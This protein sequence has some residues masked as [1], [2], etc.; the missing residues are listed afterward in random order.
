[1]KVKICGITS[2]EDATAAVE[3][4]ADMLGFN[5]YPPSP[6]SL[7]ADKA[8]EIIASLRDRAAQT[9][10]VGVFV[11]QRP[12]TV[13]TLFV[14]CGLDLVQLSGD[15][16]PREVQA[17]A[18]A[19]FK[20]IRPADAAQAFEQAALYARRAA[21][22]ALLLDARVPGQYGGTGQTVDWELA[23]SL[24]RRVP[25]LLAGGLTPENLPQAL[26]QVRPWGV[27]VAS[28]VESQPGVKDL[29][30]MA[31]FIR[32]ARDYTGAVV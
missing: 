21:A 14:Q 23:S 18:P 15:E 1:V 12:E 9:E 7:T 19:A 31:E 27:D 13:Q 32:L 2:L 26:E 22:P 16:P 30:R 5:F 4:G 24:A 29:R 10:M 28:G 3:L 25:L 8:G 20:A 6:R 11:N 17:L